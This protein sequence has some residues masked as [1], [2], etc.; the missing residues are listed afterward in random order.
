MDTPIKDSNLALIG[1][2]LDRAIRKSTAESEWNW[3]GA[4]TSAGIQIWRVEN[5]RDEHGNPNFGINK[6][7]ENRNGEFYN[8]DSYIV[9]QTVDNG[10]G[11]FDCD[12]Y[13]WIGEN[14]SQDEYGVAAYKAVELDDLLGDAPI[15]HREVQYFESAEFLN[16][17]PK[18]SIKYLDGGIDGGFRQVGED[19]G[20]LNV[21]IAHR[22]YLVKKIDR[23]TRCTQ[24]PLASSSM[25]QSDAFVLDA[26]SV[27]Y[28]WFGENCSPFEKSKASAI[29]HN[30][31]IQRNGETSKEEDVGDDN[32]DFWEA[33]GGNKGDIK[34]VGEDTINAKD[35]TLKHDPKM[36]I[37][38]DVDSILSVSE[39]DSTDKSNLVSDDVCLI[40]AGTK[41]FVW[42]GK[43]SSLR[44][45][46]QAMIL[47]QKVISGFN[48]GKGANIV[49][50]LQGQEGRVKGFNQM[51]A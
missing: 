28:S 2:P 21:N 39:C 3:E 31:T 17:F 36:Y 13:F 23:V 22:L 49:R 8:G 30:L 14:S 40:D 38:S 1:G 48:R 35:S 19:S 29:A 15:Q 5:V 7:P 45:Q 20:S 4:G 50:V 10:V 41:V 47:A 27:I 6:W 44:E 18:D 26:G 46:S 32:A 11:G 24:V 16:C 37:L 9:L 43:G 25:N 42:I 12:I 34:D 33:L 51:L